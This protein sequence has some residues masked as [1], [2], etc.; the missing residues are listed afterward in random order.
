MV[1]ECLDALRADVIFGW[2]QIRKN[3]TTS[4]AAIVSLALATGAATSAFRLIDSFAAPGSLPVSAPERLY[5]LSRQTAGE[6]AACT[7]VE[8]Q[9]RMF[10]PFAAPAAKGNAELIAASFSNRA[11]LTYGSDEEMEKAHLQYVSGWMFQ[12]FG[13]RPALRKAAH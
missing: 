4:A 7:R 10:L 1:V 8:L 12:S 11:D 13:L 9:Y 3:K 2:R 5:S 6:A